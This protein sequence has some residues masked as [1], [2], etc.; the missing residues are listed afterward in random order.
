M[1]AM[2]IVG[3]LAGALSLG[4]AAAGADQTFTA[5]IYHSLAFTC[6]HGASDTSG[7]QFGTFKATE[8]H[9]NQTVSAVVVVDNLNANTIYTI[10][11]NEAGHK[12]LSFD[13][14]T[15]TTGD[16]GNGFVHFT[17][18]AHTLATSAWVT[19][20]HGTHYVYRSTTLPINR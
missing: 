14:A 10:T 8:Q 1:K 7:Q 16:G 2:M 5:P 18:W 11:V 9:N 15:L 6:N 20:S 12:C 19:V 4:V 13:A 17:F 3:V